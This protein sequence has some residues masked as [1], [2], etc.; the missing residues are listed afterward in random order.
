MRI[1]YVS[2]FGVPC[3]DVGVTDS[4]IGMDHCK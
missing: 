3:A 2:V 1:A 4:W